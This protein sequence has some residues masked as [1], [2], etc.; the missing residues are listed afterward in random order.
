MAYNLMSFDSDF[1]S[2]GVDMMIAGDT[3]PRSYNPFDTNELMNNTNNTVQSTDSNEV[4]IRKC[5]SVEHEIK[6]TNESKYMN[7]MEHL[8]QR[9]VIQQLVMYPDTL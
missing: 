9:P 8:A 7:E 6:Q 1:Q 3:I 2:P 4:F 5:E